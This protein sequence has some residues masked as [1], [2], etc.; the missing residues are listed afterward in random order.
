[1][2]LSGRFTKMPRV[3]EHSTDTTTDED[4]VVSEFI[5]EH[6]SYDYINCH[7]AFSDVITWCVVLYGD[8]FGNQSGNTLG[9]YLYALIVYKIPA[10]VLICINS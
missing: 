5:Q 3:G 1:M 4:P 10:W 9:Y 8:W 7:D 2:K 6:L